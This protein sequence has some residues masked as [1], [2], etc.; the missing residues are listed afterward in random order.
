MLI[1]TCRLEFE[2]YG[3]KFCNVYPGFVATQA[4]QGDGMP[5]PLEVS[6]EAA[7]DH[8][9]Y[10]IKKEKKNYLFP[11]PMRWLVRIAL[12]LPDPLVS[13]VLRGDVPVREEPR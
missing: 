9:I 11:W 12:V 8:L 7:A 6:E 1:D 3:I 2:N 4:T 5:A 10:A 13:L